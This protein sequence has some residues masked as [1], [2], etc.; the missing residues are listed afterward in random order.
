MQMVY[1]IGEMDVAVLK[2]CALSWV[3][4]SVAELPVSLVSDTVGVAMVL[5]SVKVMLAL[6]VLP[7]VSGSGTTTGWAPSPGGGGLVFNRGPP[8]VGEGR[9]PAG[10]PGL[11]GRAP[12]PGVVV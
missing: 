9:A 7:G 4:L 3:M 11:E 5:S 2:A 1:V 10:G 12:G 6:A 8:A